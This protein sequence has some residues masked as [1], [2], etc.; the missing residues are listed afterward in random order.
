MKETIITKKEIQDELFGILAMCNGF[1]EVGHVGGARQKE[2]IKVLPHQI[3][4]RIMHLQGLICDSNL[5]G[6]ISLK[7]D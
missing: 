5:L 3:A 4:C 6:D 1:L 7:K 2:M